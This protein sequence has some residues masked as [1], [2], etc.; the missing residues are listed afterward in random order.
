MTT[1]LNL[2]QHNKTVQQ[3]EA[4]VFEPKDKALVQALLTFERAPTKEE[5]QQRAK[6]LANYVQ[7]VEDHVGKVMIGGA[8]YFMSEL[9]DGLRG[10]G[11]KPVYSFTERVS[12]DQ[13]Q[14]DGTVVKKVVFLHTGFVEV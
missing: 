1:I 13:T 3:E 10:I 12:Q 14:P 11:C 4:G 8:G 5:L 9:E 2:T 7:F 6:E